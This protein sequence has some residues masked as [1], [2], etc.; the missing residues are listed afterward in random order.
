M[1]L[2][3]LTRIRIKFY[4]KLV[5]YWLSAYINMDDIYFKYGNG[6]IYILTDIKEM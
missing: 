2:N 1:G 5:Y 3:N 4:L 6:L